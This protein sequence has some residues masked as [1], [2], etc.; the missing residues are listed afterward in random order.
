M[1]LIYVARKVP[2]TRENHGLFLSYGF[3]IIP[4]AFNNVQNVIAVYGFFFPL[5]CTSHW[6]IILMVEG[7]GRYKHEVADRYTLWISYTYLVS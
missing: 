3:S 1:F 2:I 5:I 7:V 4:M 6:D